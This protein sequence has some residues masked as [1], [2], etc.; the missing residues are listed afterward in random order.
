ML[1]GHLDY[2]RLD[3]FFLTQQPPRAYGLYLCLNKISECYF[4]YI[5]ESLTNSQFQILRC[6]IYTGYKER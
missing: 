2:H 5:F 6:Q 1:D 3:D 4:L